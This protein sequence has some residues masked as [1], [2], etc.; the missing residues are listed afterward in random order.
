MNTTT[1]PVQAPTTSVSS[2]HFFSPN[3][4]KVILIYACLASIPMLFN[5]YLTSLSVFLSFG[6]L[7][8]AG[9]FTWRYP[10]TA[11]IAVLFFYS[12]IFYGT[13]NYGLFRLNA[14]GATAII[15]LGW[16]RQYLTARLLPFPWPILGVHILLILGSLWSIVAPLY[17]SE[18]IPVLAMSMFGMQLITKRQQIRDCIVAFWLASFLVAISGLLKGLQTT[19]MDDFIRYSLEGKNQNFYS[20]FAGFAI[21]LSFGIVATWSHRI[22]KIYSILLIA[23]NLP[24]LIS[25]SMQA[26]RSFF[27]VA[28]I[29]IL[30]ALFILLKDTTL[31]WIAIANIVVLIWM[32]LFTTIGARVVTRYYDQDAS[33]MGLRL[34]IVESTRQVLEQATP[35]QLYL[36]QGYGSGFTLIGAVQNKVAL[37][38]HNS[39]MA[40]LVEAGILGFACYMG[41]L[42]WLLYLCTKLYVRAYVFPLITLIYTMEYS[43]TLEPH[44]M[45][46]YWSMVT[47]LY[48]AALIVGVKK[49]RHHHA[50]FLRGE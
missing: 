33:S 23:C 47:I 36:G 26:S 8:L 11:I 40:L 15:L 19:A 30:L 2:D 38:A 17:G 1:M 16:V 46:H 31:R 29:P 39:Y 44:R 32:I 13:D 4:W 25:L 6:I 50:H 20:F 18:Y 48:S 42:L 43:L 5:V 49:K 22:P 14:V 9:Y 27:L 12:A 41:F 3:I 28:I 35:T 45:L 7:C 34:T 37:A 10:H 24:V 21:I